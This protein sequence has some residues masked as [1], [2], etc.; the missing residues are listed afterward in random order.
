MPF[1]IIYNLPHPLGRGKL[2]HQKEHVIKRIGKI[3]SSTL[4][5]KSNVSFLCFMQSP[6]SLNQSFWRALFLAN[7]IHQTRQQYH[8]KFESRS[9]T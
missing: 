9:L 8:Q 1:F 4:H 6:Q 2:F 7:A 5:L 3:A